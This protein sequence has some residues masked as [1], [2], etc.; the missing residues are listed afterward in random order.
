MWKL[1]SLSLAAN[2]SDA[3]SPKVSE[4]PQLAQLSHELSVKTEQPNQIEGWWP[5]RLYASV[6]HDFKVG[7][8]VV[9][10]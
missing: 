10:E 3:L 6:G 2:F 1:A 9:R 7:T 8:A 4:N 5:K